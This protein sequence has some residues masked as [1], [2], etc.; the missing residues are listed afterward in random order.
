[1][2]GVGI[3][4][5]TPGY[6]APE[7]ARGKAVD[8]RADIWAF[9][10][11]L[12]EMLAGQ[13]A[14]PAGE[15]MSDAVAAV[16]TGEPDWV[17]LPPGLPG[18]IRRV[19]RRCLERDRDRRLHHI[20]DVRIE[21]EDAVSAAGRVPAVAPRPTTHALPWARVLPWLVAAAALG[22]AGWALWA[23]AASPGAAASFAVRRLELN[24]PAGVEL[25]T[26]STTTVALAPDGERVAFIGVNGGSR[27]VY[28]RGLDQFEATPLRGSEGATTCFFS[29]DGRAIGIVTSAGVLKTVTL[30][31][32]LVTTITD[33]VNFLYGAAWL[34]DGSI[35][36][37]RAGAL[38][39]IT[40]PGTAPKALT[41]LGGPRNETLH[42]WPNVLPDGKTILFASAAGDQWRIE[43]LEIATGRRQVIVEGGTRP[44]Y[45]TSGHLLFVRDAILLVAPFDASRLQIT[46]PAVQTLDSVSAPRPGGAVVDVSAS[47]TMV[48]EPTT[49]SSHL[50]WV[51][52]Q[53]AEAPLNDTLRS[54]ANPRI[55]PDGGR[56]VVQVGDIWVQ[57]L[58]RATFTRL[59]NQSQDAVTNGFPIWTPDGRI[60][61]RTPRGLQLIEADGSGRASI[62]P[63][64]SDFDYPGAVTAD[65]K[66]VI[67]LR[68][69]QERSFDIY[70]VPLGDA[71]QLQPLLSTPAYEGGVRLSPDGQWLIYV[72]NDSGDNEIYLRRFAG[73]DRRWQVSSDGGTQPVWN[74]NGKEVFYRSGDKMMA[75]ELSTAPDVTLSPPKLLF[76]RRYAF[77]AGIHHRQLR[78]DARRPAVRHGEG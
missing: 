18:P 51:S 9:G 11:L 54:Y 61:S 16:L 19:L 41:T 14:F 67:F 38:W 68:S 27:R 49:A 36:F 25:F 21:M 63:G 43:S 55:S 66:T 37:V 64:T 31:D 71:S 13:P 60:L 5:G 15:T 57:D 4:L 32:G 59:T 29:P 10:C 75:V 76:E 23:R 34:T 24:L 70:T 40:G 44:L 35:I 12:Y 2:T 74:P 22:V 77:G 78:R 73:S 42:A 6:M 58:A 52:R 28:L 3:V 8:Q 46:G 33:T 7:Q 69:S 1:M 45:A 17:A 30:A 65:N 62:V 20:A 50:V 26:V 48:Y 72:S 47:G 53:G 39:R 56:V